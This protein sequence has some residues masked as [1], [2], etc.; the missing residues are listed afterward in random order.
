[1]LWLQ[2]RFLFLQV[3]F[4]AEGATGG[5]DYAGQA[6]DALLTQANDL[7]GKVWPVVVA[8]VGAGLAI[9]IFKNSLQKRFEFHSGHSLP[10]Y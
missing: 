3:L 9:R 8:V 10:L 1:M 4:A 5:T 6:M 2:L 7:I